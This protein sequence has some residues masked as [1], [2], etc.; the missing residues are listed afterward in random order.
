MPV[1]QPNPQHKIHKISS[2]NINISNFLSVESLREKVDE[3][4]APFPGV[5]QSLTSFTVEMRHFE[6][7]MTLEEQKIGPR[8]YKRKLKRTAVESNAADGLY[9][10]IACLK[11][12]RHSNIY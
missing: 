2:R 5:R 4:F 8:Y 10:F 9:C 3:I 11:R 1:G 7:L 12:S 6:G